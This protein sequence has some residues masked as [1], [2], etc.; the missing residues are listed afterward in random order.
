MNEVTRA[1]ATQIKKTTK[2]T[3]TL[4]AKDV[5][6]LLQVPSNA[7]IVFRVPSGGDYSGEDVHLAERATAMDST[8]EITWEQ[9]EI[10]ETKG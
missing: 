9:V 5:R 10:E 7:S 6:E 3:I 8:L 2:T 1:V 4:T